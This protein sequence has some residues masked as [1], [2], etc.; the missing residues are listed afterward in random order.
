MKTYRVT[1]EVEIPEP[2]TEREAEEFIRFYL[3]DRGDM[4]AENP[5]ADT[6]LQSCEVK[7]VIVS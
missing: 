3:G 6:D 5:L 4:S 2:A 1:F 7:Y